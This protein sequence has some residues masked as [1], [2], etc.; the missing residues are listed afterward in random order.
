MPH[1]RGTGAFIAH[2]LL[3]G[4]SIGVIVAFHQYADHRSRRFFDLRHRHIA[5]HTLSICESAKYGTIYTP[6]VDTLPLGS[7]PVGFA[8]YF[9]PILC[10]PSETRMGI[11]ADD[12]SMAFFILLS[13]AF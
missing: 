7:I 1:L 12:G 3:Y 5:H 9:H 11:N 10:S 13:Q 6:R 8:F 4:A 2:A